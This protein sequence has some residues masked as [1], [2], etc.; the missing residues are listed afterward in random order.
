VD[1]PLT[2]YITLVT[3]S[4]VLTLSLGFYVF[5]KRHQYEKVSAVLFIAVMAAKRINCFS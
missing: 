1:S 2:A 5:I 4:A 3:V